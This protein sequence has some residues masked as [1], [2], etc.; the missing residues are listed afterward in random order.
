MRC[1]KIVI[2]IDD[3]DCRGKFIWQSDDNAKYSIRFN[4]KVIIE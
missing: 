3:N 4:D 2:R 1:K